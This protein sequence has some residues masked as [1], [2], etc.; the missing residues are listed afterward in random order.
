[1]F[2]R[3]LRVED[4]LAALFT[5]F[6]FAF[7]RLSAIQRSLQNFEGDFWDICF[8]LAPAALLTFLAS[9][10]FAF[11][12]DGPG[13]GSI[14][15]VGHV[16]RDWSPFAFFLFTYEAFRLS[17]WSTVLPQDRDGPLLRLDRFLF[18]ETPAV[19]LERFIRPAIT[20]VMTIAYFLHL[21]L[22]PV[23]AFVWYRRDRRV[24][25]HFLLAILISGIL[26]QIG[27]MLVPAVGPKRAF[28]EL[29]HV[30]LYGEV[31]AP[32]TR[33]L[34]AVRA[35]RD[36]FPS[37]HVGVSAIVLYFGWKRGRTAFLAL[38]PL[39]LL[40]WVSTLYLRYHYAVD[41][42]AGWGVAAASI[43]FAGTLLKLED[44]LKGRAIAAT[45]VEF[46]KP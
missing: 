40:N 25:R 44:R 8:I 23:I 18:G 35:P 43:A 33:A 11:Y 5:F 9:A 46:G 31:Y 26:G 22:P 17:I 24:F 39:V 19:G 4:C 37:L 16:L 32:I 41:V 28:P 6:L 30:G 1:L 13:R 12:R 21:L 42:F 10:K 29:F 38:L 2:F 3:E 27:Y 20:D 36:V 34:D 45:G 14:A 7:V 15:S